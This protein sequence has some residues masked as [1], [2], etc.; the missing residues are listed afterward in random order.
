MTN[1]DDK[2]YIITIVVI[3]KNQGGHNNGKNIQTRNIIRER[4]RNV[5]KIKVNTLLRRYENYKNM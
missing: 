1:K 3:K 4:E 5:M 2:R